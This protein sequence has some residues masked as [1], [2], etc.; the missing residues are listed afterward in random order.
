[1]LIEYEKR[2]IALMARRWVLAIQRI[3]AFT[4]SS[5]QTKD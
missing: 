3:P 5:D 1:M 2:P 4:W